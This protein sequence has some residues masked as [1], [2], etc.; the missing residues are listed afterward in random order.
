MV[1]D[2]VPAA[3]GTAGPSCPLLLTDDD[4]VFVVDDAAA[5]VAAVVGFFQPPRDVVEVLDRRRE[6]GIILFVFGGSRENGN[7]GDEAS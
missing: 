4:E 2:P 3:E 7:D 6:R 5:A 1:E